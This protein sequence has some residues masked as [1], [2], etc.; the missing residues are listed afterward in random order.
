MVPASSV[1]KTKRS[2]GRQ[3][4][5][6]PLFPAILAPFLVTLAKAGGQGSFFSC[7]SFFGEKVY[8]SRIKCGKDKRKV[9]EIHKKPGSWVY[10]LLF[11]KRMREDFRGTMKFEWP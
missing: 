9:A 10:M 6:Y 7:K 4:E 3:K 5:R 11:Q 8:G 2:A 1:G